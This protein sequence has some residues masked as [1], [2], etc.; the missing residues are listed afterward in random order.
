MPRNEALAS[1]S[2]EMRNLVQK[3]SHGPGLRS[4][5]LGLPGLRV[6]GLILQGV[7]FILYRLAFAV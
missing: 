4:K 3:V 7:G 2:P 6:P 5:N 1:L